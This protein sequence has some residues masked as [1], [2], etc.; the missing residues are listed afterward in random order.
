MK[1][2]CPKQ[3]ALAG[4][5]SVA[6]S[7]CTTVDSINGIPTNDREKKAIA[8]A[9]VVG[10]AVGAVV[11]G[12]L[13]AAVVAAA[14]GSEEQ[15]IMA[16]VAGGLAGGAGGHQ[17][18]TNKGVKMVQNHRGESYRVDQLRSM[19]SSAKQ[20]NSSVSA[21]NSRLSE[22]VSEIQKTQSTSDAR[23][24]L[25][26]AKREHAKVIKRVDLRNNKLKDLPSGYSAQYAGVTSD[27]K[28]QQ[29]SLE[30]SMAKLRRVSEKK[31]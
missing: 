22:K 17:A 16:A 18:G 8:E 27:L 6:V 21:Y 12:G 28:R 19:I 11:G 26:A 9:R 2:L 30:S 7:G 5:L 4:I 25:T 29:A 23:T 24:A 15:I 1:H 31:G 10:T 14:G 3:I 13:S 20:Y